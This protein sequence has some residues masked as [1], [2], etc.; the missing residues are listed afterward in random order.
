MHEL[1]GWTFDYRLG[2]IRE[3]SMGGFGILG[4]DDAPGGRILTLGGYTTPEQVGAQASWGDFLY[5]RLG[6]T[7]IYHGCTEGYSSAQELTML[8]RDG[9]LFQ[10]RRVLSLSGFHNFAYR[11]GFVHPG[12][13][14]AFLSGHPFA[15]PRQMAFFRKITAR[16]GLGNDRVYYGETIE[17]PAWEYWLLQMESM[18]VICEEFGIMFQAFLQPCA[19]S[20][21]YRMSGRELQRLCVQYARSEAEIRM[22]AEA[23][24][25]EYAGVAGR[26]QERPYIVDLSGLFDEEEDVYLDAYHVDAQHMPRLVEAIYA[27]M[28]E[29]AAI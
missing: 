23:F 20:G 15:T 19:F 6:D 14:A 22:F 10:P 27:H 24:R 29:G 5:K 8:L 25:E 17:M 4:E 21:Q 13:D 12:E 11:L 9:V 3:D 7:Q 18:R 16:F 28:G 2:Y 1:N 26:I